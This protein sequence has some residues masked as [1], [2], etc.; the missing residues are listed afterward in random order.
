[1]PPA[2][3]VGQGHC[4]LASLPRKHC[5]GPP[6]WCGHNSAHIPGSALPN[7]LMANVLDNHVVK[8]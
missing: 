5:P 7:G 3:E 6:Q 4:H 1:M 2:L 8:M